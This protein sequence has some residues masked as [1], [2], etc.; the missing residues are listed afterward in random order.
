MM[1]VRYT[2][3]K[4]ICMRRIDLI[5][6]TAGGAERFVNRYETLCYGESGLVEAASLWIGK[7]QLKLNSNIFHKKTIDE[8]KLQNQI[9]S[10]QYIN[11]EC[12][13][14]SGKLMLAG[15]IKDEIKLAKEMEL[16]QGNVVEMKGLMIEREREECEIIV[17]K[18]LDD[19]RCL[20]KNFENRRI[21][22]EENID[23]HGEIELIARK[24]ESSVNFQIVQG[25]GK[26]KE[27]EKE[28][29][30]E[31]KDAHVGDEAQTK[32]GILILKYSIEYG[33]VTYTFYGELRVAPEEHGILLTKAPL[34]PKA[35]SEKMTQIMFETWQFKQLVLY[36]MEI[37]M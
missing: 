1:S 22:V 12:N 4:K 7:L 8:H 32:R 36:L 17:E 19:F 33:I 3:G 25:Y 5:V 2:E 20:K 11:D 24:I 14:I 28:K 6:M 16:Q 35:N 9:I 27:K 13:A 31:R 26:K 21:E 29:E 30:R 15:N 23:K 10:M 37:Q 34:N 18:I